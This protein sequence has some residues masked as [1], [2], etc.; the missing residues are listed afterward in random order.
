MGK[1]AMVNKSD[2]E[3]EERSKGAAQEV[4]K[5]LNDLESTSRTR[6][7]SRW[8]WELLQNAR[9]A[10]AGKA[11][12]LTASVEYQE[13][14]LTFLHNGSEFTGNQVFRLIHHGST[15]V[16]LKSTIGQF[17][18]GFLSTHLLSSKIDVSG[19]LNDGQSFE[20][21]LERKTGS[22]PFIAALLNKAWNDF[23]PSNKPLTVAMPPGFTTRF[24]YPISEDAVKAVEQ[25]IDTLK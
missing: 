15:K 9:D 21:R 7:S 14:K 11:T 13:G 24:V 19:F 22:I 8:I 6:M 18:S 5:H 10:A 1:S 3:D 16:E 23:K 17:G 20:F 2:I 12:S 25:G 4:L